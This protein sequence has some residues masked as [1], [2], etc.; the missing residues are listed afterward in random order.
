MLTQANAR[1]PRGN[2]KRRAT[3][4]D[5]ATAAKMEKSAAWRGAGDRLSAPKDGNISVRSEAT[6]HNTESDSSPKADD[7]P[8]RALPVR[9]NLMD[10]MKTQSSPQ[11]RRHCRTIRM[12]NVRVGPNTSDWLSEREFS[13]IPTIQAETRTIPYPMYC[14]LI[15]VSRATASTNRPLNRPGQV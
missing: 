2:S 9:R 3:A 12:V 13:K 8:V 14:L 4:T 15:F 5:A 6:A 7:R 10:S 1:R 11:V